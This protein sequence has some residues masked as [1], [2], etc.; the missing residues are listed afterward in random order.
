MAANVLSKFPQKNYDKK[1]KL[2]TENSQN[3]YYLQNLLINISLTGLNFLFSIL[4]HMH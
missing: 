1:D 2:K 3:L 4:L